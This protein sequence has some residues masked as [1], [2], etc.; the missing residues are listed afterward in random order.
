[1]SDVLIAWVADGDRHRGVH[2]GLRD[3]ARGIFVG[4]GGRK[5]ITLLCLEVVYMNSGWREGCGRVQ[6][7]VGVGSFPTEILARSGT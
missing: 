6:R 5:R 3:T 7:T 1:M 4:D 2:S